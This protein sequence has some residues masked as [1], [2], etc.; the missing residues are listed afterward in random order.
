MRNKIAKKKSLLYLLS[1]FSLLHA[2]DIEILTQYKENG[3]HNLEKT[4]DK[5]LTDQQYWSRYLQNKDT[6]FGYF[7]SYDN[8]LICDKSKSQ[9]SLYKKNKQN[10]Y[11]LERKY[12]AYTGKMQGDK[13][14]EGDLRTPVGVYNIVKK[15][16]NVDSFYGPLAFATSYPNL[17]DKYRNKTGQG[18][19]IH[20]LPIDQN[21]DSFTKG[22]I[23]INNKNIECLNKN[24]DIKKTVLIISENGVQTK[25]SKEIFSKLLRNLF[26]WRYAW[27]Y[28]DLDTYLS[29][30]DTTF[31]RFDGMD[32]KQFTKYK[33]RVFRKKER[34]TIIFKDINITPYPN[35][36]NLFQ[37]TFQ[38]FYSAKSYSFQ[39]KK[40]LIVKLANN[41]FHIITER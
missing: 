26:E 33:K 24:I 17:Y 41:K 25:N 2:A 21:R 16:T 12:N 28:N 5:E 30:Y 40:V 7:E 22:C 19:W 4:L 14:R 1:L 36:N 23:A 3:I 18:I 10:K 20:G 39:G 35:S 9:L 31:K 32:L 8:I 27:L 38:E 15:L 11:L 34:K 37:I 13:K 6:Q 29:F